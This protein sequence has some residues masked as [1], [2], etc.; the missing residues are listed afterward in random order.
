MSSS[1]DNILKIKNAI[2][3]TKFSGTAA[4]EGADGLGYKL[5]AVGAAARLAREKFDEIVFLN[6]FV[7]ADSTGATMSTAA[8][9]A[10]V[11]YAFV[12]GFVNNKRS[13]A[14]YC[15]H[16]TYN[17]DD[18]INI[19]GAVAIIG[20]AAPMSISGTK[21][22]QTT[23]NKSLF[24]IVGA[25]NAAIYLKG[26]NLQD[27]TGVANPSIGLFHVDG[28]T[29]SGNSFYFRDCWFSTP[30]YY[31]INID[32]NSDDLQIVNCT[33]DV[34]AQKFIKLGSVT[35]T[36]TN[37]AI[38][39]N[40][41]YVGTNCQGLIDAFNV[42]GGVISGNRFYAGGAYSVPYCIN[43][44]NALSKNITI[45]GNS[46]NGINTLVS[47]QSGN[48]TITGND[49]DGASPI[50]FGGGLAISNIVLTGNRLK[51]ASG[52]TLGIIDATGTPLQNCVITN[53]RIEGGGSSGYALN[54]TL[55]T[56]TNNNVIKDNLVT[57]C[58][59]DGANVGS[60]FKGTWT[61]TIQGTSSAGSYGY[62][63]RLGEFTKNGRE[64]T[65]HF[66]ITIS[67][68]TSAGVGE[69]VI[70]GIPAT[71]SILNSV[72]SVILGNVS[73]P[74]GTMCSCRIDSGGT[75]VR[76]VFS[77]SGVVSTPLSPGN[78]GVNSNLIGAITYIVEE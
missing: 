59:V 72:G 24:S 29:T 39:G 66:E 11:N 23:A 3:N 5:A 20:D 21:I 53:N 35:K 19:P 64:M 38:L 67:A 65:I 45:N 74:S 31:A 14:I 40:T 36:C 28:T 27:V 42:Q 73:F 10:A 58:I 30:S 62:S 1:T 4:G 56:Y 9:Q 75:V 6:D 49:V 26:L 78:I 47:T 55:T 16:G 7:G 52:S 50:M 51:G 63:T 57:G 25:T 17:V 46:S 48:I 41:F 22:R 32:A 71:A 33:F 70:S 15:G 2:S 60:Y 34:T 61:P 37:I 12:N 68:V 76:L 77:G 43:F 13:C 69:I 18:T 54:T 44:P 8:F